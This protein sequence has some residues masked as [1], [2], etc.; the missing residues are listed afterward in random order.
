MIENYP[1]AEVDF[2]GPLGRNHIPLVIGGDPSTHNYGNIKISSLKIW[3]KRVKKEQIANLETV[4]NP[5][6]ELKSKFAREND[7]SFN[8]N[9]A[10]DDANN[11]SDNYLEIKN[12]DNKTLLKT[13]F[14]IKS[15]LELLSG[16]YEESTK[17]LKYTFELNQGGNNDHL[18]F[19]IGS[20]LMQKIK[21]SDLEAYM[22]NINRAKSTDWK[23]D[24]ILNKL[25]KIYPIETL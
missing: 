16:K 24:F 5:I 13:N 3:D 21:D 14:L 1:V 4:G 18:Q 20:I 12:N 9:V 11:T 17:Y 8:V 2:Q 6:Y 19:Y 7:V 25:R 22:G 10:S 23:L 15:V